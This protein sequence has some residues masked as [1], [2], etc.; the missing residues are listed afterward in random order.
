MRN[1]NR[2]AFPTVTIIF[3]LFCACSTFSVGQVAGPVA[4]PAAG[5]GSVIVHSKFGGQIFGFDIDQKGTEGVLTEA[6]SLTNGNVI[7]AIETF[8]QT[9]GKILKVVS[10]TNSQDDFITLGVVGNSVGLVEHEHEV[11]FLNIQRT[12][13]V[14]SPLTANKITGAWKG[15]E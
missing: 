4:N 8:D 13:N 1:M 6:R 15:E 7:A 9:T 12:F 11:S 2:N 3:T 5:A 10:Q 14:I